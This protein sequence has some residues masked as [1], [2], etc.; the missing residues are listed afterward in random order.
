MPDDLPP[1][2]SPAPPPGDDGNRY[3][4]VGGGYRLLRPLGRGQFGEVW[5]AEAPGGVEVAVKI[6]S[7]SLTEKETQRELRILQ[8][9]R[10]L[11]HHNLLGL[12]AFFPLDDRLVIVLELA[13]G[14]LKGRLEECR[15]AGRDGIPPDELL[16]YTRETAEALD[17]L[18]SHKLHHR[19][20]KPDNL[21][22]LG[23]H[24]KVADLGLARLLDKHLLETA[25]NAGTP[26]YTAPEVWKGQLSLHSDQY[27]LAVTYAYLRL[28]RPP[29]HCANAAQAMFA[30]LM[31]EPDL[32]PLD[33]AEKQ[34]LLRGLAKEPLKRYE[35]CADFVEAL[36]RA[37][38]SLPRRLVNSIDMEFVL[39]PAGKFVMGSP[40]DEAGRNAD[41]DRHDV[42]MTRPFYLGVYQVTQ[43]EYRKVMGRNPSQF[44]AQGGG[45]AKVAGLDTRRFPV[46]D[47]SWDDAVEFCRHLSES[48]VE[49]AAGRVYRLPTEA[50]WE[51]ACR[52]GA[53]LP[54]PFF[55]KEPSPTLS[56]RQANFNGNDPGGGAPK[57]PL[58]GRTTA[59][60]SY[61]P[62]VFGLFDM[63][64]NVWEWC[65]DWYE[66]DYYKKSPRQNPQGPSNG[67]RRVLRG[68]SWY[69]QGKDCRAAD[70]SWNEPGVGSVSVGFRVVVAVDA[71][72]Q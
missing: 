53:F 60:G 72:T 36:T 61:E 66:P 27:S 57:G 5:Q 16:A 44:S 30:H 25:S 11:R 45:K 15:N 43:E 55:F 13:D 42:E 51:Y 47:V 9:I 46:E 58:L 65:Q 14:S 22:L 32:S 20:I 17:Y 21:L 49:K 68:G 59:V 19:D 1:T 62:N 3:L 48:P 29:Y 6:I 7:R 33:D 50:E 8:S 56:S 28:G 39:I 63:H 38:P 54:G 64:G 24:V 40:P 18:H 23:N 69:D 35:T 4:P 67:N 70:R 41:E 12:Q 2:L 26:L 37:R 71:R 31:G 10:R 52:G 34:A